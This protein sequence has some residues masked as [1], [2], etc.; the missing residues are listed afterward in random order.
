MKSYK[1]EVVK[2]SLVRV[3]VSRVSYFVVDVSS[4]DNTDRHILRN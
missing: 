1:L 2:A 3:E 4:I